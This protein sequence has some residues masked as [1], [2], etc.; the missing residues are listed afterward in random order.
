MSKF[1]S[2]GHS[3]WG[4]S[5]PWAQILSIFNAGPTCVVDHIETDLRH[6]QHFTKKTIVE[7]NE[8]E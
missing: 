8:L 7:N 3:L 4:N 1:R 2:Y 6:K 5:R